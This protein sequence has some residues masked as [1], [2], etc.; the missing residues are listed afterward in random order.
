MIPFLSLRFTPLESIVAVDILLRLKQEVRRA[1]LP[2]LCQEV[3]R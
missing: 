3:G 1:S 2:S